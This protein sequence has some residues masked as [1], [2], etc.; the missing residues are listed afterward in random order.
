MGMRGRRSMG[1]PSIWARTRSRLFMI[2]LNG[3]DTLQ[4]HNHLP[5]RRHHQE[6]LVAPV[7]IHQMLNEERLMMERRRVRLSFEAFARER[8]EQDRLA[9]HINKLTLQWH[10]PHMPETLREIASH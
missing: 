4:A 1:R 9:A 2:F 6:M 5:M 3:S 8:R 10:I 7:P